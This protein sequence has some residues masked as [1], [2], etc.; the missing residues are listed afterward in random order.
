MLLKLLWKK[1]KGKIYP[2]INVI[3]NSSVSDLLKDRPEVAELLYGHDDLKQWLIE[4]FSGN[5]TRF[6]IQ[7]DTKEPEDSEWAEHCYPR[8][9]ETAKIRVSRSI[10]GVDQLSGV[11][12]E[13]FNIQNHY[14][15]KQIQK[16]A[17][18]GEFSKQEYHLRAYRLEY[19]AMKKCKLFLKNH[20][21]VFATACDSDELYCTIMSLGSF[22]EFFANLDRTNHGKTYFEKVYEDRIAPYRRKFSDDGRPLQVW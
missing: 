19:A 17:F 8:Q 5:A 3:D 10:S 18:N 15:Y 7:W 11:V 2:R 20:P 9:N 13:L 14:R 1:L 12:Y 16:K 6:P 4:Q 22:Q 21:S